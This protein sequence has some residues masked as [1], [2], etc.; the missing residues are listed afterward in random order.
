MAQRTAPPA[1]VGAFNGGILSDFSNRTVVNLDG[2]MNERAIRSD[3]SGVR[4]CGYV[5]E[6]RIDYLVDNPGAIAFF[7]DRDAS[8]WRRELASAVDERDPLRPAGH[9]PVASRALDWVVMQRQ[10]HRKLQELY[11]SNE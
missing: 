10:L 11:R 1:I 4:L 5:A 6:E 3:R 2:V 9:R 8:C 7:F